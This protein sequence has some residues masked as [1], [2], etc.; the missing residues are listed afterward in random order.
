MG[1]Y[2]C[3]TITH[4]D[5]IDPVTVGHIS[6]EISRFFYFFL[7]GVGA[8][9]GTEIDTNLLLEIKILLH[10]TKEHDKTKKDD[11]SVLKNVKNDKV[12]IK[13]FQKELIVLDD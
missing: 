7:H 5:K 3:A 12:A 6:C 1:P 13:N 2:C 8:V 4:A 11:K 9:S 10:F